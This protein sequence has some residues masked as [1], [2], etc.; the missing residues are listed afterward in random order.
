MSAVAF[1]YK[2]VDRCGRTSQGVLSASTQDA[3]YRRLV[4]MGLTPVKVSRSEALERKKD[5]IAK[6]LEDYGVPLV[7]CSRCTVFRRAS[8]A[9]S[10]TS[11]FSTHTAFGRVSPALMSVK[12]RATGEA[13]ARTGRPWP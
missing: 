9:S 2:A 13:S 3:A 6:I 5:E 12:A 1:R 11:G 10:V 8:A 4:S 7:A